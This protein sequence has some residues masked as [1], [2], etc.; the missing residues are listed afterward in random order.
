MAKIKSTKIRSSRHVHKT[1]LARPTNGE[2]MHPEARGVRR[3][4]GK[5]LGM[6]AII[7]D[8]LETNERIQQQIQGKHAPL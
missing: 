2:T 6:Q 1:Q 7:Q 3:A 5:S 4:I 8:R